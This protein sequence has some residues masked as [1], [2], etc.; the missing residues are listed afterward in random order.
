MTTMNAWAFDPLRNQ[1]ALSRLPQPAPAAGELL[2]ENLAI[3]INPVDW[4][5]IQANPLAWQEGH[6]PGVD[7]SG[8]VV[9]VGDGGDPKLVGMQVAYHA[10]LTSDGSFATHTLVN[11]ERV[12]VTPVGMAA[13]LAA[14]L[15]CP[16]LTAWQAVE[17]IPVKQGKRALVVGLGAVNKL[18]VQL[19]A[20][21]GFVI[22]VVSASLSDAQAAELGIRRIYR[23]LTEV[24][25]SYF[26]AFDAV[27]GKNAAMVVPCLMANG[28]IVCIQDRIPSPVDAPFT[29]TI[30]YHEIA[31]GA[32]HEYGDREAWKELMAD[33]ES[34]LAQVLAGEINVEEP[35]TFPFDQLDLALRHSE[36]TKQKTVVILE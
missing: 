13:S 20:Q 14:A 3:G 11:A 22:D 28:H 1:V 12:M 21:R 24:P 23:A 4:K 19:L 17:K 9:A 36:G 25:E 18:L 16:M 27:G 15:P 2:I 10:S 30:S 32:L 33:G 7:G 6:V 29:R 31:L 5:F 26:A 8:T 35:V 34:L